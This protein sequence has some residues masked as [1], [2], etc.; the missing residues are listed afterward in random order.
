MKNSVFFSG[1]TTYPRSAQVPFRLT[2][3]RITSILNDIA[4]TQTPHWS[5]E[6]EATCR[7]RDL[8]HQEEDFFLIYQ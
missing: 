2:V 5:W 3:K 7:I 1:A 8:L 6:E 4:R